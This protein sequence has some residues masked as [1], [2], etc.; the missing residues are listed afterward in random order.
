MSDLL[1]YLRVTYYDQSI[2]PDLLGPPVPPVVPVISNLTPNTIVAGD[3]AVTVTVTGLNFLQSSVVWADEEAQTTTYISAGSLSYQAQAD[4]EGTQDITV[5]QG[6]EVS[7]SVALTVEAAPE[8]PPPDGDGEEVPP[9][10]S[11]EPPADS[12]LSG[13]TGARTRKAKS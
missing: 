10:D 7:N 12:Q 3:P 6:A 9:A 4:Q 8:E 2:P 1:T 5:R 13:G 11:E